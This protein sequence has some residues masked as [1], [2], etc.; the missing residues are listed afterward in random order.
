[1]RQQPQS[2]AIAIGLAEARRFGAK[3]PAKK[4]SRKKK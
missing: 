4:S 2:G 3:V 1:L